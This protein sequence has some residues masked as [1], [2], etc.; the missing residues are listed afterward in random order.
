VQVEQLLVR[1]VP[2]FGTRHL[3]KIQKSVLVAVCSTYTVVPLREQPWIAPL[4][5]MKRF[6]F[7]RWAE[8]DDL[9]YDRPWILALQAKDIFLCLF[10]PYK[11]LIRT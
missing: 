5:S 4:N 10:Y 7:F 3:N 8:K 9:G 11:I 6:A 1:R 2:E